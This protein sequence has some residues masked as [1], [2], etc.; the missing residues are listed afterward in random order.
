MLFKILLIE[1]DYQLSEKLRQRPRQMFVT[2]SRA[3][4]AKVEELFMTYLSSLAFASHLDEPVA[5]G[6]VNTSNRDDIF[7]AEDDTEWRNDLPDKFSELEDRHFPLFIAF[8]GV[9][10]L[11][12]FFTSSDNQKPQL[13][14]MIEADINATP[15]AE[16]VDPN[17][18]TIELFGTARS[19]RKGQLVTYDRFVAEYCPRF[20]QSRFRALDL[21]ITR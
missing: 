15:S 4:V 7:N 12:R 5:R 21:V 17:S 14:A 16:S 11:L 10:F 13:C 20:E 3:L 19:A 6:N 1:R 8:D 18:P 9:R 2:Q